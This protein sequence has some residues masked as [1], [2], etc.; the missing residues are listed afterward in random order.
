MVKSCER[1]ETPTNAPRHTPPRIRLSLVS[2]DAHNP[3][4]NTSILCHPKKCCSFLPLRQWRRRLVSGRR[5]PRHQ[6]LGFSALLHFLSRGYPLPTPPPTHSS[7]NWVEVSHE[8][9]DNETL[10]V[11]LPDENR[12]FKFYWAV[13]AVKY[14]SQQSCFF[15]IADAT[16]CPSLTY[17]PENLTMQFIT[18]RLYSQ[19]HKFEPQS[20][21]TNTSLC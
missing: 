11:F 21:L 1:C 7:S 8:K 4:R 20:S 18:R 5:S 3:M 14:L 15:L 13:F 10:V 16:I 17:L 2:F 9:R 19:A 6:L 12:N